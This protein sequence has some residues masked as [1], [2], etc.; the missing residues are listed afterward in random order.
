[1][2]L[3]KSQLIEFIKE[4]LNSPTPEEEAARETF[5][6]GMSMDPMVS[7]DL[8]S[9]WKSRF[10]DYPFS[11]QDLFPTAAGPTSAR[12][13]D[14]AEKLMDRLAMNPKMKEISAR[15]AQEKREKLGIT[16]EEEATQQSL[17]AGMSME[18]EKEKMWKAIP[19]GGAEKFDPEG[20]I[21]TY[22]PGIEEWDPV[23]RQRNENKKLTRKM[24]VEIIK[25]ELDDATFLELSRQPYEGEYPIG[26]A[27]PDEWP[28]YEWPTA[29]IDAA[30]LDARPPEVP[31]DL[32]HV[33][34][35]NPFADEW[36]IGRAYKP[37]PEALVDVEPPNPF[38]DEWPLHRYKPEVLVTQPL[39]EE[40]FGSTE[41]EEEGERYNDAV[42]Q[43]NDVLVGA[44]ADA[45]LKGLVG[46]TKNRFR[47]T[48]EGAP[49]AVAVLADKVIEAVQR[50][51]SIA[52]AAHVS[53]SDVEAFRNMIKAELQEPLHKLLTDQILSLIVSPLRGMQGRPENFFHHAKADMEEPLM[54][55]LLPI[56]EEAERMSTQA[57]GKGPQQSLF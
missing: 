51:T 30:A 10:P 25:E 43:V 54:D 41:E 46:V 5:A 34:P 15:V 35:P 11:Q 8:E 49:Q 55:M 36:P 48:R 19:L 6:A 2:K 38:A 42:Y 28:W 47:L 45:A 18:P 13:M 37:K 31:P 17:P 29:A 44:A 3:T 26:R 40:L 56:S 20:K 57:R 32:V 33:E 27:F 4:E 14:A 9:S 50:M 7:Y 12:H 52:L 23:A 1:M 22:F 24:L 39:K 53:R 21:I 16:P